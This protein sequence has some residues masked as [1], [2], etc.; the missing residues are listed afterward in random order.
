MS[1]ACREHTMLDDISRVRSNDQLALV[2]S[3]NDLMKSTQCLWEINF[4]WDGTQLLNMLSCSQR[5]SEK[6][7]ILHTHKPSMPICCGKSSTAQCVNR[8]MNSNER[9]NPWRK[10]YDKCLCLSYV[11]G[12]VLA[13][14]C[15]VCSHFSETLSLTLL[16]LSLTNNSSSDSK[17]FLPF[18]AFSGSPT[19]V[20]RPLHALQ[21]YT[22]G[23][24]F[25][26]T[27]KRPSQTKFDGKTTYCVL[28]SLNHTLLLRKCYG[29]VYGYIA[30]QENGWLIT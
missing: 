10:L 1:F 4:L 30:R 15:K 23:I 3:R 29:E 16:T 17:A 24:P 14:M 21:Y 25:W 8:W 12:S 20:H 28:K 27:R 18:I 9:Q 5:G 26:T 2:Q 13:C 7:S 19:A 22:V 11:F 6:S